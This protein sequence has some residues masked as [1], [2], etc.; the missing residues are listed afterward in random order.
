[1]NKHH[2]EKHLIPNI[3]VPLHGAE[4]V[5][6]EG[7]G[8]QLNRGSSLRPIHHR[9]HLLRINLDTPSR[10]DVAQKGNGG[11]MELILFHLNKQLV[12]L[13]AL[14]NLTWSTCSS[15]SWRRRG[16]HQCRRRRAVQ[17]VVENFILQNL[18]HGMGI[19]EAKGHDQIF[20]VAAGR[21]EGGL[22]LVL[23]S[24]PHQVVGVS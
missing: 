14:H 1:V 4:A 6:E 10:E 5:G 23:F 22:S 9:S 2:S 8:M 3:V 20:V 21:V 16:C 13:K 24:Y 15:G 12:I 11:A 19:V 17:H 7:A 18:E